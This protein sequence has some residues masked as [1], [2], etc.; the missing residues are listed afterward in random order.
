MYI[1]SDVK[2]SESEIKTADQQ[3][4]HAADHDGLLVI[5]KEK[6]DQMN[7]IDYEI[8]SDNAAD[9]DLETFEED[10]EKGSFLLFPFPLLTEIKNLSLQM[11]KRTSVS[12]LLS[13]DILSK[14][15][16]YVPLT[17]GCP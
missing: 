9:E 3:D 5:D 2:T 6:R 10:G 7:E 13:L 14:R 1:T 4:D 15:P 8:M 16:F 11:Y 17:N 12:K